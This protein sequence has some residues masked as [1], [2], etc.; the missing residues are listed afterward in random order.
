VIKKV[1]CWIRDKDKQY[2]EK[3]NQLANTYSIQ[4]LNIREHRQDVGSTLYPIPSP[5]EYDG[6]LLTGGEDI[7]REYQEQYS[8]IDGEDPSQII[9]P[10]SQRD[11]WEFALLEQTLNKGKP[12]LCICRGIQLLNIF[13]GGSLSLN[14]PGHNEPKFYD[15]NL[16]ELRVEKNATFQFQAVNSSHHQAI[17]RIAEGLS[18]EARAKYDGI[19][20]QLRLKSYPFCIG[21]QYHPERDLVY[22][23]PVFQAFFKALQKANGN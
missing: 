1:Y 9:S 13:L 10:N 4:I 23:G 7:S 15:Q 16:Q 3:L 2:F 17:K 5:K 22:Y 19:I 12:I 8:N 21:V 6:L 20:E 18:I 11:K 14:I